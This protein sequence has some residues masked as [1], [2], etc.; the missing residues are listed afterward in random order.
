MNKRHI[1]IIGIVLT[2][3]AVGC[4]SGAPVPGEAG[5][6]MTDP[7]LAPGGD[8]G[9]DEDGPVEPRQPTDPTDPTEPR[10]GAACEGGETF[11]YVLDE[12]DLGYATG[13]DE[14]IVPGFDL[15]NLVS[16]GAD[17][18]SC[19][20]YDYTS[21]DGVPGID[22]QLGPAIAQ[23]PSIDVTGEIDRDIDDGGLLLLVRLRHVDDLTNDDCVDVD[24]LFAEMPAGMDAPL[25][26]DAERF[27]PGQTFDLSAQTVLPDGS[28]RVTF[29]GAT[30]TAGHLEAESTASVP[31]VIPTPDGER[32]ELT[33]TTPRVS[34]AVGRDLDL[35]SSSV[36]MGRGALLNRIVPA[37]YA[38]PVY[39]HYLNHFA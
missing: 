32:I 16:A 15:D 1:S 3:A 31:F 24:L 29:D 36:L 9:V 30:L 7:W 8:G 11:V 14:T 35:K 2:L 23:V 21:P 6:P 5:D 27:M 33:L 37:A 34:A 18:E 22:N 38:A 25:I 26:G 19:R 20:Q 12:I 4:T 10:R 39:F 13:T 28:A 17:A